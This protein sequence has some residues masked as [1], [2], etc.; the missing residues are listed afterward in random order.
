MPRTEKG[1]HEMSK[2]KEKKMT[3]RESASSLCGFEGKVK[4]AIVRRAEVDEVEPS[5]QK[6]AS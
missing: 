6:V 5:E 4:V 1:L 3:V 2:R